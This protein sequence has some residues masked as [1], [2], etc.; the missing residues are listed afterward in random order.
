MNPS[1][2][3][4]IEVDLLL[5]AI[6]E[7]YGHDFRNYARASI[8]RRVKRFLSDSG[9]KTVSEMIP[10]LLH[11]KAFFEKMVRYFS[12]TVTEMFRDPPVYQ[13]IRKQVVPVLKTYP[14]IRAWNAGCATGEEAYSLAILLKE[15]GM[16][17]R[18]TLFAT[19]F[20]DE[21]LEKAREGIYLPENVK[22]AT[23]NY[24]KAGGINSFSDY[25]HARYGAVAI[26]PSLKKN[27]TF[28]NHNLVTDSVFSEMH[29][30]LCRNVLI[31]FSKPLQDRVLK[32]FSESLVPNGF[33]CLGTRESIAF[34]EVAEH[35][36]PINEKLR[37]FQ[38]K[39]QPEDA[40]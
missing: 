7:R 28:A 37:I 23:A 6:F 27:I 30:I 13:S 29:L 11:E 16:Y 26:D 9:C 40:Q 18:T 4:D 2:I 38:K 12:I 10:R 22:E 36:K 32:L 19:D 1:Q 14:Y 33:L 17:E 39:R 31:Y 24:Q 35:F 20:N 5:E 34:S 21:A 25:Y 8:N 3:K 15:E